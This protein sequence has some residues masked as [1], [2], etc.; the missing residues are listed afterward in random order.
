MPAIKKIIFLFITFFT[1]S[2]REKKENFYFEKVT[3]PKEEPTKVWLRKNEN[4]NADKE[5][6]LKVFLDNYQSKIA[7]SDYSNVS[8]ILDLVTT[9]FVYFYDFDP[10]LTKVVKEFNESYRDKLPPLKTIYID[11]YYG[12]LEFDRD[13]LNKAKDYFLKITALEPDDYK[14]CYKIARAYYDLS[15]TYFVLGDLKNSIE[16]NEKSR[17]YSIRIRDQESIASVESNYVNIYKANGS[18]QKAVTSADE[19]IKASKEIGN[20]YDYFMGKYNKCSVYSFFNKHQLKN[21]YI[22]ETYK[23]YI[24]SKYDN[25]VLLLCISDYEIE[26]LIEENN[27]N[28]AKIVLDRIKPVAEKNTSQNWQKDYQATLALYQI[29]RD[30]KTCNTKYIENSLPNLLEHKNYERANLFY[31]VL[32]EKAIQSRDLDKVVF[33]NNE[34]YRTK[35]SLSSAKSKLINLELT[36]K[37]ETKEKEQEIKLQQETIINKN[38]VIM[39]L[40][41]IFIALLLAVI[42]YYLKQKQK[43]LSLEKERSLQ[44][45]KNL[46]DKTEEE[47]KRIAS[48]LH[49]SVSHELLS[50]KHSF[51]VSQLQLNEKVDSIINDIRAISRNLHPVLFEKIGLE[52]SLEQF[53][54]RIQNT[55]LFMISSEIKYQDGLTTEKELQI[56]RIVQE[57]VSNIIKYADAIAAKVILTE[58]KDNVI[59]EI[60]DNGKGFNVKETLE[61]K[62]A[63]GLHNMIERSKAI[64]G[65]AQITSTDKGT[66]IVV[67]IKK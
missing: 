56:Y 17:N 49:D 31:T 30:V 34:V 28:D 3:P 8:K 32:L 50:L 12:N 19:V 47:R 42:I 14:S 59:L 46:L 33:Y 37:Y 5:R 66:R 15:Y 7:K 29:T 41:L 27:L 1:L 22:H 25:D 23:E 10:R 48:D 24:A 64:R 61:K 6:Y 65:Q 67:Q 58:N 62:D 55:H 52:A 51:E 16:A 4:Y 2:C 13:H 39:A 44:F 53:I 20:T 21:K 18:F 26:A 35:D 45:T 60:M 9:K 36:A 63:F 54:E 43:K 57:A 38:A 40:I 11:S